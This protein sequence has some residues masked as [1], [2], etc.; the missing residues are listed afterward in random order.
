MN[1]FYVGY[2]P[3]APEQLGRFIRNCVLILVALALTSAL[4]LVAGQARFADSSFEYQQYKDYEGTVT[5][6]PYPNLLAGGGRYLLVAPGKFGADSLLQN[7]DLRS[8]R[9][10]GVLIQSGSQ[11]MLELDPASIRIASD[12]TSHRDE[13]I[14][15]GP[16]TLTGEIAD[17]K[18]YVGAMNPGIGKVHRGCAVR[19]ISG[20]I[21]PSFVVADANGI[22]K[23]L[24]L[25][26]ADGRKLG[27][28]V[29]D[30]VGEPV[31]IRGEVA[32]LG[33]QLIL[34]AEPR[35]FER[36]DWE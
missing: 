24:L 25:T 13:V 14:A 5:T 16:I 21:S 7:F 27:R 8:V 6:T 29:L 4:L 20:G 3:K 10:R 19:C 22:H 17:S 36:L 35:Q 30:Y 28:E 9:L 15:L 33:D 1:D 34:R 11:K 12:R 32:R 23:A 18:C 2:L 31:R 26:G